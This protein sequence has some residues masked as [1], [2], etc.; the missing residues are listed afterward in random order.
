MDAL[1]EFM[2][3]IRAYREAL[4][5]GRGVSDGLESALAQAFDRVTGMAENLTYLRSRNLESLRAQEEERTRIAREIHDGPTQRMA[6]LVRQLE[7]C[8]RLL[9]DSRPA[10][11][12]AQLS[13]AKTDLRDGIAEMRLIISNLRPPELDHLGLAAA[14]QR[15]AQTAGRAAGYEVI[16]DLEEKM[17]L[18]PEGEAV[19]FRIVQE[20]VNN[21]IKHAGGRRI[22]IRSMRRPLT[23]GL[24][25]LSIAID[26]DGKG[27]PPEAQDHVLLEAGK[28][29]LISM[30]ERAEII[31]AALELG[32][33]D[34]GGGRVRVLIRQNE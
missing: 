1:G 3:A 29:G 20:A 12:A 33:S 13:A 17:R 16:T 32:R 27:F 22:R 28:F 23:S 5:S 14:V 2:A 6:A 4:A 10:E 25:E 21:V 8:E 24:S 15:Y 19:V 9:E 26:D 30:R 31:G 18:S 7:L 34:L 11:V